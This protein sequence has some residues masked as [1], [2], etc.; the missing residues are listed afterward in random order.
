MTR[1]IGYYVHHQGHGHWQRAK[2]LARAMSRPVTLIGTFG[3]DREALPGIGILD[4]PDDRIDLGFDGDDMARDRP[5]AFHYAPLDIDGIRQRMAMIATWCATNN[6]TL[7]VVDV[8]VEVALFVR[9]LS[10]PTAVVRLAGPRIDDPHLEAFR[11]ADVVLAPFPRIFESDLT[12]TW[13]RDKTVYGGLLAPA[14]HLRQKLG[15][16]HTIVVVLGRGGARIHHQH[17]QAA[18][19]A[20]PAYEW[21]VF[22]PVSG[23]AGGSGPCNLSVHG[24]CDGIGLELDE[25]DI[26]IGGAGDGLLADVAIR[27]KRFICIPEERAFDEQRDKAK[28]LAAE[29]MALVLQAWPPFE[30]WPLVLKRAAEIDPMKLHAQADDTAV[31]RFAA[32][33]EAVAASRD[34]R[35]H[36]PAAPAR[37]RSPPSSAVG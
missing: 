9:L 2:L 27:A 5:R 1:P 26:V 15:A 12:P 20:T 36:A 7:F 8:S 14:V 24:W 10:V 25:A 28:T 6:P 35:T 34:T 37:P 18:A 29:D 23:L 4:L 21:R 16:P 33:I 13:V 11:A 31:A 17:L 32:A 30:D 22:G 3:D 19:A